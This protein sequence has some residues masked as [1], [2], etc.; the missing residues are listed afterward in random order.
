MKFEIDKMWILNI[1]APNSLL[2][3]SNTANISSIF[4]TMRFCSASGGRGIKQSEIISS[5][6]FGIDV[7]LVFD[8]RLEFIE[9][10]SIAYFGTN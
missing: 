8:K 2:I 4:E 3:L 7:T 9:G 1:S 5:I 6:R 10:L